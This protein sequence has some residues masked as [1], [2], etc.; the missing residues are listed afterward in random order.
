[1]WRDDLNSMKQEVAEVNGF[2]VPLA[3]DREGK[4]Q[5]KKL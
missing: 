4:S 2:L 1:L 3:G 5:V